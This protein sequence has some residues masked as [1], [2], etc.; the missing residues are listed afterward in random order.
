M[1]QLEYSGKST[2]VLGLQT[3][4]TVEISKSGGDISGYK[5][6]SVLVRI[7]CSTNAYGTTYSITV[8]TQG[9]SGTTSF[10]FNS[11]NY[12]GAYIDMYLLPDASFD[13]NAL[14]SITVR[15]N[16]NADKIYLKA[17][18]HTLTVNYEVLG[19]CTPPTQINAPAVVPAGENIPIT[20]SGQTAGANLSIVGFMIYR[21]EAPDGEF[22]YRGF[23]QTASYTD[24]VDASGITLYYK[25]QTIASVTGYDSEI[26]QATSAGTIINTLPDD[27]IIM[28][29]PYGKTY[30]P[31]P[32]FLV[33]LG[34]DADGNPLIPSMEGYTASTSP[35]QPGARVVM[36][37]NGPQEDGPF[38]VTVTAT[39]SAGG[40]ATATAS[41]GK[42]TP[43]WTDDPIVAGTTPIKAAH[44]NELR[45]A[46]DALCLYYGLPLTPWTGEVEAGVTPSILWPMHAAEIQATIRRIAAHINAWDG[47]SAVNAVILPTFADVS[48]PT[49][50]AMNQMRQM[51]ALL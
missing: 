43:A 16:N 14:Q 17:N 11:S 1:P 13:P 44:I 37:K 28:G 4:R 50:Y 46:L 40:E 25:V 6:T 8:T 51:V 41:R 45:A 19:A 2:D 7:Y 34:D 38:S 27:P 48:I 31:R 20:W 12:A 23:S 49:A 18:T 32:R 42:I 35:A 47:A 21:A 3:P 33:Q 22:V 39:D 15:G 9:A 10:K 29:Q 5:V 26:S 24:S 36:R 30:N